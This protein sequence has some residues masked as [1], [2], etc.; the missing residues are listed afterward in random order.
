M[1][2]LRKLQNGCRT[3]GQLLFLKIG[4]ADGCA[5]QYGEATDT[6]GEVEACNTFLLQQ[7][8]HRCA[9]VAPGKGDISDVI[10]YPQNFELYHDPWQQENAG[11]APETLARMW[12][13]KV[14]NIVELQLTFRNTSAFGRGI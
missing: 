7:C 8:L 2:D 6:C 13:Q 12:H 9:A 5:G 3:L 4:L 1:A 14:G 11:K 10:A